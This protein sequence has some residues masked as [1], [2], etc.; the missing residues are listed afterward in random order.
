MDVT[1]TPTNEPPMI[2]NEKPTNGSTGLK[3]RPICSIDV[4]DLDGNLMNI[5]WYENTTGKWVL[6]Q[7]NTKVPDCTY[8]WN[9][10][11]AKKYSTTYWWKVAV[12]DSAHNITAIFHFTTKHIKSTPNIKPVAK[13]TGLDQGYV[14][15]TLIF[16]AYDSYDPDGRIIGYRWDFNNDGVFD[17]DWSDEIYIVR[18]YSKPGNYTIK[19]Q[20]KD[21][22]ADVS[23]DLHTIAILQ[24]GPTQQLPIAEAN[25]PYEGYTNE[26]I[27]FSSEGSYDINGTIVN[28]TWY[29]GDNQISYLANP[30]HTY[31]KPGCYLVILIVRNNQNLSNMDIA[32]A[33]ITNRSEIPE[34][35]QGFYLCIPLF[36]ILSIIVAIIITL[37]T[38]KKYRNK[39]TF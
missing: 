4:I 7:K 11:Q 29:F 13:I 19:L 32:T 5:Y 28:Y 24:L 39:T 14:N 21:N 26:T 12:N 37:I 23:E 25:G 8:Q 16:F 17:T 27:N 35:E 3:P 9:F 34:K 36:L 18:K 31:S 30:S 2:L 15:Q 20:V 38:Y 33:H 1:F 6:R 10:T 22:M